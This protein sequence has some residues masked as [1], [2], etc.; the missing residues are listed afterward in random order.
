MI[1]VDPA[2]E[3]WIQ[4][5]RDVPVQDV[6]D[7]LGARLRRASGELV[8]AC[9]ACGGEDRFAINVRDQV[10]LCRGSDGKGDGIAM[11]QHVNGCSFVAAVEYINQEPP[12]R[13]D[14]KADPQP[15]NHEADKEKRDAAKRRQREDQ[16]REQQRDQRKA[17][18]AVRLLDAGTPIF[19]TQAEAYFR[20]RALQ[21]TPVHFE[22]ARFVKALAYRGYRENGPEEEETLGEWPC[23]LWPMVDINGEVIGVHR[24]YLDHRAPE[25]RPRE[26][27]RLASGRHAENLAKKMFGRAGLIRIT[28][29]RAVL[30]V[31]EGIETIIAWH[32]LA[33]TQD[34]CAIAAAGSLGQIAGKA[35]GTIPHPTMHNRTIPNGE[36]D[37]AKAGM[38]IPDQVEELII[39]GDGDSDPANTR[40]HI[41]TGAKRHHRAGR[42]VSIHMAPD[43]QDWN[44]VLVGSRERSS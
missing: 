33:W 36:P 2:F 15:I 40:A 14:R 16:E 20:A 44:D 12:P 30:A 13:S 39:C 38:P 1:A 25:K 10:F 42:R 19:G 28:P 24:T 41:L 17:N 7:M 35:T 31:A 27:V 43:G 37:P 23:I 26:K 34:D 9:P 5:A 4:R 29:I 32:Q 6:A 8:G 22:A 21:V 18:D 11:V 3:E